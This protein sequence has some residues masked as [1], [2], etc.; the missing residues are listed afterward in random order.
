MKEKEKGEVGFELGK[1][2]KEL[3]R[4]FLA[5][6]YKQENYLKFYNFRQDDQ[7][8]DDYT[9]EFEYLMLKCDVREPEEQTIARYIGGLRHSIA[10]V[11]CLQPFWN[12]NDVRKLAVTIE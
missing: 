3:R 5:D 2:R 6:T 1:K 7:T 9:R 10:D 8:V 11:I 12:F 4:C